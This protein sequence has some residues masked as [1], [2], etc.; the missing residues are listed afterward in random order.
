[1][2]IIIIGSPLPNKSD[3]GQAV[4]QTTVL[5][6]PPR[7]LVY[8]SLIIMR[9]NYFKSYK[10]VHLAQ[11]KKSSVNSQAFQW[12]SISKELGDRNHVT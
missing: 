3:I 6:F 9:N 1:M 11:L 12:L 7:I 4:D 8:V 10:P 2:I 5:L